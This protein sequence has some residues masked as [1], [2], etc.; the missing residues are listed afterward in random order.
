MMRRIAILLGASAMAAPLAA[1]EI[2][3]P[4]DSASFRPSALPGYALAQRNCLVCHSA[5][6]VSSQPPD[7]DRGYWQQTVLKMKTA[8]GWPL[9]DDE[10]GPIIDYL[11]SAYGAPSS[12]AAVAP[13]SPDARR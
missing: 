11:V 13:P 2:E 4:A 7:A 8:F 5:D 12:G 9:P 10:V 1:V 6:Y 3:L